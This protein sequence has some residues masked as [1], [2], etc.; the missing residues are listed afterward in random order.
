MRRPA[1]LAVGLLIALGMIPMP[2]GLDAD[3]I[4]FK[5]GGTLEVQQSRLLGDEIE[6]SVGGG[7]MLIP[8]ADV[9]RIERSLTSPGGLPSGSQPSP[10]PPS[11]GDPISVLATGRTALEWQA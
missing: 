8:R 7:T 6:V 10:V 9:D 4:H 2:R 1:R 11:P 3:V 5:N